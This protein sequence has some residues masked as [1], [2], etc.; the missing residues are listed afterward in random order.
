LAPAYDRSPSHKSSLS[1]VAGQSS[2]SLYDHPGQSTPSTTT[3]MATVGPAAARP[4]LG[5]RRQSSGLSGQ[6]GNGFVNQSQ[7]HGGKDES[8]PVGFDEGI[9]R[10]LCEMDVSVT[11][12]A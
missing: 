9:L 8:V 11:T 5:D 1:M 2:P 4:D 6:S 10:G 3:T 7:N 12:T